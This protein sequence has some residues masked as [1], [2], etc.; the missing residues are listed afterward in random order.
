MKA[1][2]VDV[3]TPQGVFLQGQA[4][5]VVAKTAYGELGILPGHAPLA[6]IL[7][8]WAIRVGEK[9]FAAGEGFL[10]VKDGQVRIIVDSAEAAETIDVAL[11][12]QTRE[13]AAKMLRE[14]GADFDYASAQRALQG[15]L[16]RL[17]AREEYLRRR[18]RE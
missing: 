18:S 12:Q 1:L 17:M 11:A 3:V 6:A 16:A 2:L 10:H 4:P 14:G 8:P 7:Q 15:A 9:I 5:M 13:K